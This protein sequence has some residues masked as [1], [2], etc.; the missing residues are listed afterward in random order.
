MRL[1]VWFPVTSVVRLAGFNDCRFYLVEVFGGIMYL[2][3]A[4]GIL[5]I[6]NPGPQLPE[7]LIVLVGR[8]RENNP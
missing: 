3:D 6:S 7:N 4:S 5:T 8:L 2:V 1:R